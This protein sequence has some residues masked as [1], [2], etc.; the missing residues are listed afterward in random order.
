MA[1]RM[2]HLAFG[3]QKTNNKQ[4]KK[5]DL[6]AIT[7]QSKLPNLL[8]ANAG[9]SRKTETPIKYAPSVGSKMERIKHVDDVWDKL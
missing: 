5:T 2:V 3:N 6:S 9:K 1:D 8:G 4:S 7:K